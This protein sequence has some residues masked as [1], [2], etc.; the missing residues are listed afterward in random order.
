MVPARRRGRTVV[1]FQLVLVIG[2][3]LFTSGS[4]SRRMSAQAEAM[5]E[6]DKIAD[7]SRKA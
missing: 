4:L 6:L 7:S 5:R 3:A 1:L 2:V